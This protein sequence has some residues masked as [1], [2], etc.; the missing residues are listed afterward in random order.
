MEVAMTGRWIVMVGVL[1]LAGCAGQPRLYSNYV[2]TTYNPTEF[3][4]GAGRKDLRVEVRGDP[5]AMGEAAF[6]EATVEILQRF[7]PRPQP[8][9]FT[10]EPGDNSNP[11]YRMQLLFDAPRAVNAIG[12]CRNPPVAETDPGTVQ[13]SAMFCRNQGTLTQVSGRLDEVTSVD[14]PRFAD[15]MHQIVIDLFPVRDP[16]RDREQPI[17]IP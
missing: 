5:F 16:Q 14:D 15:L 17:L 7:Q 2:A 6:A 11:A 9:H 3:G 1:M 10:L 8:T 13:V 4:V 12:G